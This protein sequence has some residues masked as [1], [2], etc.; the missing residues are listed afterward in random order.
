[1]EKKELD[2][3]PE[4]N[5][6]IMKTICDAYMTLDEGEYISFYRKK[7]DIPKKAEDSTTGYYWWNYD[8]TACADAFKNLPKPSPT[9]KWKI[10]ISIVGEAK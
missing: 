10:K 9:R 2:E 6:Y 7:S 5:G 4:S 3:I 1:M 8:H